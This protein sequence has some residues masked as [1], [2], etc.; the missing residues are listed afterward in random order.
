MDVKISIITP[1]FNQSDFIE[2]TID[3]V[4]SQGFKNL[5]YIIIDGGSTD[6]SVDIIKRYE[7]HLTFWL[8][9]PDRGQSHAI[10]KGL[11][12][13]TGTAVNWLNSD[14]YLE[15]GALKLIGEHFSDSSV[16]VLCGRGN[17]VSGGGVI[18]TSRGTDTYDDN[19]AKTIGMARIDQPE[20][21][22]RK[23]I[24]DEIGGLDVGLHYVMD[25]DIWVRYLLKHGL[26]G[27]AKTPSL[28][29]NFRLHQ[30]SKTVAQASLFEPETIQLFVRMAMNNGF[31]ESASKIATLYP[32]PSVLVQGR[33]FPSFPPLVQRAF[34]YFLLHQADL[35]YYR[36]CYDKTRAI[37]GL[38]D[39]SKLLADDLKLV[40]KLRFR[41][42]WPL[43]ALR[44]VLAASNAPDRT[45]SK[46][47]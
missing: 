1:S 36:R 17:I 22:F 41:T 16:N 13:A 46:T 28:L 31:E 33:K 10:R 23:S 9:E 4:L 42:R 15:P 40:G 30:G 44:D 34:Q 26:K 27:I 20:T 3:S 47:L 14:D 43:T 12:R 11:Q 21:W 2:Q 25:K 35:E 37:L 19:L 45:H 38:I 7:K 6:G 39:E 24:L 18:K 32:V 29:A 5:E 8:S